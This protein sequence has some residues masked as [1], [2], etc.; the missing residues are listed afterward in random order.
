MLIKQREQGGFST[1]GKR[2][3]AMP[4]IEPL[5]HK[6]NVADSI[7]VDSVLSDKTTIFDNNS[8]NYPLDDIKTIGNDFFENT[9]NKDSN[10][11][12]YYGWPEIGNFENI[13]GMFE[14]I[15]GKFRNCDSIFG[16]GI[17]KEEEMSWPNVVENISENHDFSKEYSVNDSVMT[18]SWDSVKSDDSYMSFV[19]GPEIANG[20]DDF[21]L[22]NGG[23]NYI[24]DVSNEVTQLPSGITS[25]QAFLDVQRQLQ[26]AMKQLDSRTKLCIRDSLYRLA[27]SANKRRNR[28]NNFMDIEIHTNPLD[29]SIAH[30]LFQMPLDSATNPSEVHEPIASSPLS[31]ENYF[32]ESTVVSEVEKLSCC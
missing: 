7:R 4:E 22:G 11:F 23:F 21:T 14:D 2:K 18:S 5:S 17:C 27:R 31:N 8:F 6:L 29:R 19:T 30:L 28:A 10:D 12:L 16:I 24:G 1:L 9:E 26:H 25:D 20:K 15:D 3:N 13:D 32:S